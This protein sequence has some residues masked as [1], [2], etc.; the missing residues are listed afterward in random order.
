M[1]L[2]LHLSKRHAL[3]IIIL[4]DSYASCYILS[5]EANEIAPNNGGDF[6]N[7]W[8]SSSQTF[9]TGQMPPGCSFGHMDLQQVR[10]KHFCSCSETNFPLI[11]FF[12]GMAPY[13]LPITLWHCKRTNCFPL[14][15][16][17]GINS[18]VI[19]HGRVKKLP[20]WLHFALESQLSDPASCQNWFR[21][22]FSILHHSSA[23]WKIVQDLIYPA[24]MA[25]S[26][27]DLFPTRRSQFTWKIS[28][29]ILYFPLIRPFLCSIS[30]FTTSFKLPQLKLQVPP[31][32]SADLSWVLFL[33]KSLSN[34]I[35]LAPSQ[36]LDLQWWGDASM[37]FGIGITIGCYWAIWKWALNF[38]VGLHQ[39][40][41]IGWAEAV[42][43][44][45]SLH[46][47]FSLDLISSPAS[48]A[49]H[50]WSAQTM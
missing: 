36:L 1:K 16:T 9:G 10:R 17:F 30:S 11:L 5:W 43:V 8:E 6:V 47:T 34:E 13:V 24:E 15:H 50:S 18:A 4:P 14:C 44:E 3:Q 19:I 26:R 42:V 48:V 35:P 40:Y 22:E 46:L 12:K 49:S 28:S 2:F 32:L 45:L 41:N 20:Q 29:Y 38:K 23:P 7:L 39:E 21:L 25:P 31:F 27:W 37:S 33:V